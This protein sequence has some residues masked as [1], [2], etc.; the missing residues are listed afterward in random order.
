MMVANGGLCTIMKRLDEL[1]V[2]DNKKNAKRAP[3]NIDT[4]IPF[5]RLPD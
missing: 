5:L 2:H 1:F 4:G 3:V